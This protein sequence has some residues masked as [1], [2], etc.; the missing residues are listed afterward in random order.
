MPRAEMMAKAAELRAA[1]GSVQ[2]LPH[3]IRNAG[4]PASFPPLAFPA[5][6]PPKQ[7]INRSDA[8]IPA[9][10]SQSDMG[11]ARR[12]I[13]G[14]GKHLL[15]PAIL[16]LGYKRPAMLQATLESLSELEGLQD[17]VVYLSQVKQGNTRITHPQLV[18]PPNRMDHS[19]HTHSLKR[20]AL[21]CAGWRFQPKGDAAAGSSGATRQ[22]DTCPTPHS[23]RRGV[24]PCPRFSTRW[25][26]W[27][28][29]R[30]TT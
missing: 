1:R 8:C 30:Y 14:S 18:A 29:N 26:L 20:I 27:N 11:V 9:G 12:S 4:A 21:G 7:L 23:T 3:E 22:R 13:P 17:F 16:L 6:V 5:R 10:L 28:P 24:A 25:A 15:R 2:V 19:Y